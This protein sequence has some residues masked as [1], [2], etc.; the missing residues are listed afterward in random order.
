[1]GALGFQRSVHRHNCSLSATRCSSLQQQSAPPCANK[2]GIAAF[3][4]ASCIPPTVVPIEIQTKLAAN[5]V[6]HETRGRA[7]SA[8]LLA[9]LLFDGSGQRLIPTHA[10]KKGRRYRYYVSRPLI[11]DSR[12][13]ASGGLRLPAGEI[14]E[15]VT[16]EIGGLLS[17]PARLSAALGPYLDTAREQQRALQRASDLAASWSEVRAA[18]LRPMLSRL[19][20]RIE[21]RGDRIDLK[22]LPIWLAAFL[23]NEQQ[24]AAPA[25][26]GDEETITL[27]VLARLRRAGL[28][29]A[30]IIDGPAG[31]G[32]AAKP[33]PRLVKLIA[34][35]CRF[36]EKL[37]QSGGA[38]LSDVARDEKLTGSYFTRV[39]R[40]SYLAPDITRAILEGRH[41][42][43]LTA[44]KLLDH[45][46]L[47]L[48]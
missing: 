2:S 7:G 41:P 32:R 18:Q 3:S 16:S 20:Q 47:P 36:R 14:E 19:V 37:I 44:A 27:S 17:D 22:L 38:H 6:E 31:N 15:I 30:M 21:V 24:P 29:M 43:D 46:R 33:D 26:P 48:A 34:R 5:A 11:T 23:R 12:A 39:V 1:M 25:T 10:V 42:R 45:S 8:S 40:L 13:D 9:G 35:A 4:I 28:G